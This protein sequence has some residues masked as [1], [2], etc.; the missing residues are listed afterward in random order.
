MGCEGELWRRRE[1]KDAHLWWLRRIGVC[2]CDRI[3]TVSSQSRFLRAQFASGGG[4]LLDGEIRYSRIIRAMAGFAVVMTFLFFGAIGV[5]G[6]SVASVFLFFFTRNRARLTGRKRGV[7]ILTTAAPFLAFCW[8]IVAFILH[9][10]ISNNLA[11]QDCG[12]GLS[13]DPWVTLPNGYRLGSNNTYDGYIAA[14]GVTTAQPIVGAGY[15]RSIIELQWKDPYFIGT[16]F[17]FN[18]GRTREFVYNTRTRSTTISDPNVDKNTV[19]ERGSKNLDAWA[20]AQTQTH[21]DADSYWVMYAQNRRQWPIYAFLAIAFFGEVA[22]G[23]WLWRAWSGPSI[24]APETTR[25]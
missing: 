21:L 3:G 4:R 11:H 9:V 2:L 5:I 7:V 23:F 12:L 17:D 8:L 24:D 14:P 19:T 20:A 10:L 18:A 25:S 22:I 15:V 16:Q 1:N 6:A 13:P